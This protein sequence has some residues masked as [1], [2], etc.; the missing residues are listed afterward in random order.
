MVGKTILELVVD[1]FIN[2]LKEKKIFSGSF[3][4][5]LKKEISSAKSISKKDIFSLLDSEGE[6]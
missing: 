1:N 2:S 5:K 4:E 6:K 3:L